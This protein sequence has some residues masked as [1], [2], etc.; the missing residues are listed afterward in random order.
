MKLLEII[1]SVF[2]HYSFTHYAYKYLSTYLPTLDQIQEVC[3]F[4]LRTLYNMSRHVC[5][6]TPHWP[7]SV[8]SRLQS[9]SFKW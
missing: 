1:D 8:L 9:L 3:K 2:K 7:V 4:S 5:R 6:Q